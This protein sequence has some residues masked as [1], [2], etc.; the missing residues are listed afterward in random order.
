M[1]QPVGGVAAVEVGVSDEEHHPCRWQV[2][3]GCRGREGLSHGGLVT[4]VR[5]DHSMI[6]RTE[7]GGEVLRRRVSAG[8]VGED[9]PASSRCAARPSRRFF[10]DRVEDLLGQRQRN[11]ATLDALEA[12]AVDHGENSPSIVAQGDAAQCV[13]GVFDDAD[14]LGTASCASSDV[15]DHADGLEPDRQIRDIGGIRK[16]FGRHRGGQALQRGVEHHGV[17]QNSPVRS[18]LVG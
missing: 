17:Q 1:R 16:G 11:G 10:P 9:Q 7:P 18:G 5:G 14:Q 4:Q 2:G 6:R 13:A 8:A 12:H 3:V 15:S